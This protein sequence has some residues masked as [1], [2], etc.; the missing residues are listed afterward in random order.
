MP[1]NNISTIVE[2]KNAPAG[3]TWL[4]L[5]TDAGISHFDGKGF[6]NIQIPA[7]FNEYMPALN[8]T[9]APAPA[10]QKTVAS[11]L[12]DKN[13]N[14]WIGT[15][16]SG[17]YRYDG[18]SFDNFLNNDGRNYNDN[19][20]N[21]LIIDLLEDRNGD[22]WMS[23]WNRGGAWRYSPGSGAFSNFLSKDGLGDDMIFCALE[24]KAGNIWFGTR[25]HGL[26]RYDGKTFTNITEKEGLCNPNISAIYLDSKGVLWCG[27]DIKQGTKPGGIC[28]YDGQ[29]I[30]PFTPKEGL[31]YSGIRSIVE[32]NNG[33]LWFGSRGGGLYRYDGKAFTDFSEALER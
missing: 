3:S 14:L 10:S 11:L 29:S 13:G 32:D 20:D 30:Q 28:R 8:R 6:T 9:S 33:N 2:D 27:S 15:L 16:E 17:L 31:V 5:G 22:I 7:A 18:K 21:Q 12:Q 4:W 1:G 25:D 19:R 23:S 26:S 24:D